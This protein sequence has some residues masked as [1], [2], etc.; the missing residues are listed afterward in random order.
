M[1]KII[2]KIHICG[3]SDKNYMKKVMIYKPFSSF[4]AVYRF[5][6][7]EYEGLKLSEVIAQLKEREDYKAFAGNYYDNDDLNINTIYIK[8]GKVLLSLE[9]DKLLYDI[10]QYFK[11]GKIEIVHFFV[12][13]GASVANERGY[14]F[15]IY[16]DEKIHMYTPHVHVIKDNM[17][18]RYYLETLE[19]FPNDKCSREYKRDEK[20]IIIPAIKKNRKELMRLWC[21]YNAGYRPPVMDLNGNQ[22]YKES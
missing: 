17:K 13:G 16:P 9:E 1:K 4:R 6:K 18:V 7:G 14:N 11:R 15:V 10:F 8:R 12:A 3:M 21:D 20:K 2:F 22:Y 5:K 19:R